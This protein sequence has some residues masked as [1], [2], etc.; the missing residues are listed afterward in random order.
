MYHGL[1]YRRKENFRQLNIK[2][3]LGFNF[4]KLITSFVSSFNTGKEFHEF[5]FLKHVN[6]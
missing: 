1:V 3:M 6:L 2:F 4:R 5:K